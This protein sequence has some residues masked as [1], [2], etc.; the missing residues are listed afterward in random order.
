MLAED[1][2]APSVFIGFSGSKNVNFEIGYEGFGELFEFS[3]GISD[4]LLRVT[5]DNYGIY[6]IEKLFFQWAAVSIC[7]E[8]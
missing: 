1:V 3:D 7:M 6:L 4:N 5:L 2:R 8:S